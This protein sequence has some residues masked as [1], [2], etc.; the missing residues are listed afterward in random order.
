MKYKPVDVM[1]GERL[2]QMRNAKHF[3]LRY[4]GE[5]VGRSNVTISNYETGR[6]S[7]DLPTLKTLCTLYGVDMLEFLGEIYERL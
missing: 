3:S 7:I 6:L 4:V 1:I 2:K 5:R